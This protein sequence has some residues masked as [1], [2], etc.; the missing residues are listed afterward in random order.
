MDAS[1]TR[2]RSPRTRR[3]AAL[4]ALA[5]GVGVV[6]S[7]VL[8]HQASYAALTATS[9]HAGN[10]WETGSIVLT[11]D[12][13]GSALFTTAGQWLLVGGESD[14]RCLTL[15]SSGT[16]PSTVT[17]SATAAGPLAANL[18]TTVERGRAAP[19]GPG[20]C[21]GFTGAPVYSGPLAGLPG[22]LAGAPET[23]AATPGA[24]RTY[25]IGW[26][27]PAGTPLTSGATATAT[28]TWT[29][30]S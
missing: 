11:D 21:T 13:A 22:A 5:V 26:S 7:G 3:R 12:A 25:R 23:W 29:A 30:R 19:T 4:V 24:V 14:V 9:Q 15:T 20:D 18:Q 17:M 16:L 2:D 28:F 10:S 1:T 27:L 8:V 6:G